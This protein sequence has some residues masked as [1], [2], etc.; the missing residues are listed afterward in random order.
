MTA[1]SNNDE[2]ELFDELGA[3]N[4]TAFV[5]KKG[6]WRLIGSE[7]DENTDF[8]EKGLPWQDSAIGRTIDS[9]ISEE[10]I[11][12]EIMRK[13]LNSMYEDGKIT[14]VSS[15]VLNVK[16]YNEKEWKL[17]KGRAI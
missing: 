9:F 15:S 12:Q 5:G 10:G 3:Y 13:T 14:P 8:R 16:A 11:I 1:H 17:K 2:K 6:K 7:S 4:Y